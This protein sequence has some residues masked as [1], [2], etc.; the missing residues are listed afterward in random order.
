M[1]R[2]IAEKDTEIKQEADMLQAQKQAV[3]EEI[4]VS[5]APPQNQYLSTFEGQTIADIR[6]AEEKKEEEK[7][8]AEKE[9]LI[10]EQFQPAEEA[11]VEQ[12]DTLPEVSEKPVN[13]IEKPNYDLIEE[14]KRVIKL[15][16][17]AK[18][19]RT[20]SKKLVGTILACVLGAAA[21]VCVANTTIIDSLSQNLFQ[22]EQTYKLRLDKYLRNIEGLDA[23]KKNAEFL[24]TY[25]DEV[26]NAG[27]LGIK[28]NWFDRLCNFIARMFGG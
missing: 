8:K 19:Q 23:T 25:P 10:I 9:Q 13:I 5:S 16:K 18:P 26:L 24:E 6:R 21:I 14:P 7:F 3:Q 17:Q 4:V 27:D 11:Q 22:I 20:K 2:L 28:S 1:D 12:E 15:K